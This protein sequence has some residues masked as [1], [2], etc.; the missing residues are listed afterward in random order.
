MLRHD[1]LV[2]GSARSNSAATSRLLNDYQCSRLPTASKPVEDSLSPSNSLVELEMHTSSFFDTARLR[3]NPSNSREQPSRH[4]ASAIPISTRYLPANNPKVNLLTSRPSYRRP[5]SLALDDPP[6]T[7]SVKPLTYASNDRYQSPSMHRYTLA[8]ASE[9]T[10]VPPY[11]LSYD[12]KR[13]PSPTTVS[14]S[15]DLSLVSPHPI[16]PSV[17]TT[18]AIKFAPAPMRRFSPPR[19]Q[20]SRLVHS[21]LSNIDDSIKPA[22]SATN[23]QHRR[24]LFTSTDMSSAAATSLAKQRLLDDNN[25]FIALRIYD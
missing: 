18:S 23:D 12:L 19:D 25:N 15:N 22:S 16:G 14:S 8:T 3:D 1:W 9:S 5:M 11:L 2:H 6:S 10:T 17:F 7:G 21:S 13:Q 20:A 24:S 4:R